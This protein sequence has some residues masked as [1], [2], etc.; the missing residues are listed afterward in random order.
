MGTIIVILFIIA[1]IYNI[2]K[3]LQSTDDI[4]VT[5]D[6]SKPLEERSFIGI[7]EIQFDETDAEALFSKLK[8]YY[9]DGTIVNS[10]DMGVLEATISDMKINDFDK[11]LLISLVYALNDR[12]ITMGLPTEKILLRKNELVYYREP[13]S[14]VY[15]IDTVARNI[16]YCGF[17]TNQS[18]FRTGNMIVKSNEVKGNKR[19]GAGNLFVTN[20][21]IVFVGNDNSSLNIPLSSIISYAFYEDNG[22]ILTLSNRKPIIVT[23]PFEGDFHNTHTESVGVLFDDCKTQL[24]YA[25][26]KVFELRNSK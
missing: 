9:K 20:Q 14:V 24:L 19:L 13:N 23:F 7:D 15:N 3:N 8:G 6:K 25:F 22:V 11:D 1:L 21:R 18:A 17:K 5:D 4:V 16:S 26:D 10:K 12:D 2:S